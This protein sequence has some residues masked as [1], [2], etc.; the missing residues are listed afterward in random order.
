MGLFNKILA[1][2]GIGSAKV[3][4]KLYQDRLILGEE[5]KGV[6]EIVGGNLDQEVEEIYLSLMTTYEKESDDTTITKQATITKIK[7]NEPFT[8]R[9]NE[10][11]EIPFSFTLPLDTP[12]TLGRTNVW[13]H[14]GLEIKNAVDP[15]DKDYINVIPNRLIKSILNSVQ[16]LGFRL[17]KVDCEA[18]SYRFRNRLPFVQEFEFYPVSGPFRG[19]LD[20]IELTFTPKSHDQ[21]E[22]LMQVDRRARG[23][24]GLFAEALEMDETFIRFTVTSQ[25]GE[26]GIRQ[27]LMSIIQKYS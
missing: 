3:D 2:V 1:S 22:C 14:T 7:I 6:V 8:I 24:S 13:I 11:K 23:L 4:T 15:S 12:I 18:V 5:V 19:K 17:R 9:A 10:R 26:A 16:E 21:V 20:E 25:D 27:K